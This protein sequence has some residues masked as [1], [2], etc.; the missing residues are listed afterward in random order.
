[1]IG[2]RYIGVDIA[3]ILACVFVSG[4]HFF[5]NY[6][7][8]E[9][10]LN[11]P[12]V[13]IEIAMRW[14]FFTCV[15]IFIVSTGYLQC[16]KI[17]TKA[18]YKKISTYIGVYLIYC[19]L[20]ALLKGEGE[21]VRDT[22]Q[23]F[24]QYPGYFWYMSF[25]IGLYFL[26][27]YLNII[28]EKLSESEMKKFIFVLLCVTAIPEFVNWL[29]AFNK[30]QWKYIY[31]PNW[32]NEF[33]VIT[34][35]FIGAYF[36]K[37]KSIIS[38]KVAVCILMVVPLAISSFDYLYSKG[39]TTIFMGGGYGSIITVLITVAIFQL[40]CNVTIK[41]DRI[42]RIITYFSGLTFNIYLGLMISDKYTQLIM[43]KF[44][45][46]GIYPFRLIGLELPL[47]FGIALL[48]AIAVDAVI[49]GIRWLW[50]KNR[51]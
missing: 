51:G 47:N 17:P 50:Q 26:L 41:S 46:N 24:F 25:F 40:L 30:A 31:L 44:S 28:V 18:H 6:G 38:K 4:L 19:M 42:C 5:V 10:I 13:I 12:I 37:Y 29:P 36:R 16:K 20:T 22:A 39:N 9:K 23:Y 1:M 43:Q 2:K 49:K 32:W 7:Y 34:Y 27:P 14:I 48:I 33:F 15:G 21:L 45:V 8:Q 35:Y 3:K 11:S